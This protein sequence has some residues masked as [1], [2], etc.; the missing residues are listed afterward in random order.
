M[1]AGVERNGVV[2]RAVQWR[3]PAWRSG[4]RTADRILR[5]DDTEVNDAAQL[6][7]LIVE[8]GTGVER[9]LT[10]ER[11]GRIKEIRVRPEERPARI[12]P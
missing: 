12:F 7:Q 1:P 3:S 5:V 9:E 4:L 8:G 6:R 2:L 10:I 11:G